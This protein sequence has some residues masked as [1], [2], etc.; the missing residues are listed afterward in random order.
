MIPIYIPSFNRADSIKTPFWLD[1]SGIDYR[2]LLHSD[3]CA[4]AYIKAGRV[5]KSKIIVTNAPFGVTNHRNW[6]VDNLAQRG[7]WYVS[8][9]DN[10]DGMKRVVDDHYHKLKIDVEAPDINQET[11]GHR[12]TS[13]EYLELLTADIAVAEKIKAESI[14]YATV[15]NYYFNSKKYK[16][17]GYV[18]SKACA[19]K[20][21]GLRYDPQLEAM[22]DF[23]YCASQLVK[24]N[25][26]LIN[27]WIKP[28]AGHYESGGIGTYDQRVPRK[29]TDCAYLMHKYPELFRYKIKKDCHPKAE[30][31]FRFH[32]PKQIVAWKRKNGITN[33]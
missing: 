6:V 11:F 21:A 31:Q 5:K 20:F 12:M 19:I 27:S 29:I 25:C 18:I 7:E 15:D 17:V 30:L 10:I 16:P 26:V 2:V 32:S 14:G 23:G 9:D 3:A 4:D 28:V 22:E 8:L 24:N 13:A 33:D 1:N